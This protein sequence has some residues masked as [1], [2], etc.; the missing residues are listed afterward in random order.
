MSKPR[1]LPHSCRGTCSGWADGYKCGWVSHE[2]KAEKLVEALEKLANENL[3]GFAN[4]SNFAKQ[5]LKEYKGEKT[6]TS[7]E[8]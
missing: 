1:E 4:V 7:S 6:P 5:A 8:S 2:V 3:H